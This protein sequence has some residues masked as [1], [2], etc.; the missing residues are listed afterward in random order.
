M[1]LT[2]AEFV[3]LTFL[4]FGIPSITPSKLADESIQITIGRNIKKTATNKN[5]ILT[6]SYLP[7]KN[8]INC[9]SIKPIYVFSISPWDRMAYLSIGI[10]KE[11]NI[12]KFILVPSFA[13]TLYTSN[14]SKIKQ[15]ELFQFR[16]S[17]ELNYS[18]QHTIFGIGLSHI[19][20]AGITPLSAG[21]DI[22][23]FSFRF[24]L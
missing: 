6:I 23:Y 8:L 16:T 7:S 12:G 1:I 11:I 20:N 18:A 4:T 14:F 9:L 10:R 3:T 17:L 22:A 2:Y 13:P 24:L 5:P 19:S 21:Q 15:K